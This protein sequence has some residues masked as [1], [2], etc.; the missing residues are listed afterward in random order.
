[1]M[2][3]TMMSE[4]VQCTESVNATVKRWSSDRVSQSYS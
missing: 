4:R 3:M 2:S 1:M